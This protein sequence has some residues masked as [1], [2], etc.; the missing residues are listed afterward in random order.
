MLTIGV[1]CGLLI[2]SLHPALQ[3]NSIVGILVHATPVSCFTFLCIHYYKN[4]YQCRLLTSITTGYGAGIGHAATMRPIFIAGLPLN[5]PAMIRRYFGRSG[6]P[7][8][9]AMATESITFRVSDPYEKFIDDL[10][11]Q[12]SFQCEDFLEANRLADLFE[13]R[14]T[15]L[16]AK[17][18]AEQR[19]RWI[20]IRVLNDCGKVITLAVRDDNVYL[21]GFRNGTGRW[22]EFGLSNRTDKPTV[23]PEAWFLGC[24]IGYADMVGSH[25]DLMKLKLGRSFVN[26]A[27]NNLWKYNKEPGDRTDKETRKYLAGLMV[28]ICEAARMDQPYLTVKHGW[29]TPDGINI[30]DNDVKYIQNWGHM[31]GALLCW[32]NHGYPHDCGFPDTHLMNIGITNPDRALNIVRLVLRTRPKRYALEDMQRAT[33][34]HGP[35]EDE[36]PPREGQHEQQPN[37]HNV[38]LQQRR[39][40][41]Q[42]RQLYRGGR[43]DSQQQETAVPPEGTDDYEVNGKPLVEVYAV[44]ARYPFAGTIAIVDEKRGQIIYKNDS[45]QD[46]PPLEDVLRELLLTG[47]YIAVSADGSFTIEVK[48]GNS[49]ET[50]KLTWD[51]TDESNVYDEPVVG[52]IKMNGGQE[53]EVTYAVLDDAVEANVEVHLRHLGVTAQNRVYGE[54]T[55]RSHGS[56]LRRVVLLDPK[57]EREAHISDSWVQLPLARSVLA[58]PF[59]CPL[60]IN[61]T[62]YGEPPREGVRP[63]FIWEDLELTLGDQRSECREENGVEVK[64]KISSPDFDPLPGPSSRRTEPTERCIDEV[65][66][67]SRFG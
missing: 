10:R 26:E 31:S 54:I 20:H 64:V 40:R 25:E 58:V 23:N 39:R 14:R 63:I 7:A 11:G 59:D 62:L 42:Q 9:W 17:Y 6:S 29:D 33:Q 51:C 48:D 35:S 57:L 13:A 8:T 22:Y 32:R 52:K 4:G 55:A 15:Y 19:K 5:G 18:N 37:Q 36:E 21:H 66:P 47:P 60:L 2:S 28:I 49:T 56:D 65:C 67:G 44:R 12:L 1:V 24:D 16:L 53:I 38:Q 45:T 41:Q 61:A 27:V 34:H 30:N 50:G 46:S 3:I 43:S